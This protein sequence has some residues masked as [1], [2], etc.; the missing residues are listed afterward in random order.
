[1]GFFGTFG[2]SAKDGE[3]R[4]VDF[5]GQNYQSHP[6]WLPCLNWAEDVRGVTVRRD[7]VVRGLLEN[8]NNTTGMITIGAQDSNNL[9]NLHKTRTAATLCCTMGMVVLVLTRIPFYC[10]R[11]FCKCM[12][13]LT[14]N[15]IF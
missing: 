1:M 9:I 5:E 11:M 3:E 14:H 15:K 10:I 7:V 2:A 6:C 8:T 4:R 12:S 13:S